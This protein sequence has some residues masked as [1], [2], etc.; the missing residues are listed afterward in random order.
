MDKVFMIAAGGTGGHFYPGY[1]LA[2]ELILR[3]Q[4]VVFIIGR[5]AP[6]TAVLRADKIPFR[7]IDFVGMP[8]NI[9]VFKWSEFIFKLF[10]SLWSVRK[11]LR[12]YRPLVCVGMGGYISFPL[13]F[14]ARMMHIKTAIHDSNTR[15][16]FAN[17][18]LSKFTDIV[19]LG[20]PV[21]K[22]IRNAILTGTPIREDFKKR[23]SPEEQAYW[24]F[25][26][27]FGENILIFGGSQG[28]YRLN[29]AAAK[30]VKEMYIVNHKLFFIHVSGKR[31]FQELKDFY[32]DMDNVK[33][34]DYAEDIYALM[35][36]SQLIIAR[37]GASSLAEVAS[38]QKPAILVPY[39]Y[40]ADNHQYYNARLLSLKGCAVLIKDNK[41]LDVN[42]TAAVKD[43]VLNPAK[44]KEMSDCYASQPIPSP[45]EAAVLVADI[46]E[47]LAYGPSPKKL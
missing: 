3:G 29:M 21:N 35:K 47:E 25:T 9:N 37:S 42:L 20:L 28:A 13:I 1:A 19:M 11:A 38:L 27:N 14:M 12:E 4:D 34:I 24:R 22:K 5:G 8:R 33:L 15:V 10:T 18:L 2:K 31:D 41:R 17:R 23:L 39:P 16:G 32:G 44:L 6:A 26:A 43:L 36:T 30:M 45:L 46:L 7:E 40:A